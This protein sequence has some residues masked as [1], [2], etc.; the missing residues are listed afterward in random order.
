ML[1]SIDH[2]LHVPL[3]DASAWSAARN[4]AQFDFVLNGQAASARFNLSGR[5]FMNYFWTRYRR[6]KLVY[7]GLPPIRQGSAHVRVGNSP[8]GARTSN[9][10]Q[11]NAQVFGDAPSK[12]GRLDA[13]GGH[14]P[15]RSDS[16]Y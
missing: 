4:C 16:G 11:V 12:R 6:R 7:S 2:S 8:P 9:L 14:V 5:R 10:V 13:T 1:P 15:E 3:G